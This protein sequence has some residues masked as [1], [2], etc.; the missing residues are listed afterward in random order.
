MRTFR[1]LLLVV[2]AVAAA[3]TVL[4]VQQATASA[5]FALTAVDEAAGYFHAEGECP[6]GTYDVLYRWRN[7]PNGTGRT[8]V[9]Q[10]AGAFSMN[11]RL[12]AKDATKPIQVVAVCLSATGTRLATLGPVRVTSGRELLAAPPEP[13]ASGRRMVFSL[14]AEQLWVYDESD[15]LLLTTMGSGRRM[16][17]YMEMSPLGTFQVMYK[18][19]KACPGLICKN[20]IGFHQ[21]MAGVVGFHNIPTKRGRR[22]HT[23]DELG[24]PRS[25]GCIHLSDAAIKWLWEWSRIGDTVVMIA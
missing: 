17:L 16:A 13:T 2:A 15:N 8:Q 4:P 21:A 3:L 19:L 7:A 14:S 6:V 24:Q 5:P 11:V 20:F 23:V 1:R 22:T 18:H 12:Q 9:R 25:A 10:D